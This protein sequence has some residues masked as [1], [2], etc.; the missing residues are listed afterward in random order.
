MDRFRKTLSLFDDY[1]E[2]IADDVRMSAYAAAIE[3]VVRPGDVV[4]DLGAGLGIL[5]FLAV[6]AGASRVYAIEKSDAIELARRVA[7]HNGLDDRI[8]FLAATSRDVTLDQLERPADVLLS[9]TLGSFAV[10]ENTL[11][12]T[13]D[14]RD[15]LLAAGARLLPSALRLWLAPVTAPR[16]RER[17]ERWRDVHGIDYQPAL[18]Q[19]LG[20]MSIAEITEPQL[21]AEPQI[22]EHIELATATTG[23]LEHRL[24]FDIA[25]AGTLHGLAGWFE[26]QLCE[27][28]MIETAPDVA[29]THW[30]QALFPFETSLDV[31]PGDYIDLVLRV[32]PRPDDSDNTLISYDY[33]CSQIS[34]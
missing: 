1:Y 2:M 33:F 31:V 16:E 22:Y 10:D 24:R 23:N 7:V 32:T 15:R 13:I 4:I 17:V 5:S 34:V 29:P 20:R 8:T 26:A 25:R 18:D 3:R 28:V 27:G 19:I 6:R 12:F 9:E 21:L 11:E 14:C 30:K